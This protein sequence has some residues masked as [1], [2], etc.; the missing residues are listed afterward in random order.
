MRTFDY[1]GIACPVDLTPPEVGDN[2]PDFTL[3]DVDFND[4]TLAR[5]HGQRKV[6]L[7]VPSVDEAA[8]ADAVLGVSALVDDPDVALLVISRDTPVTLRRFLA[9]R[10]LMNVTALS[11]FRS[12]NFGASYGAMITDGRYAALFATCVFVID[13]NDTLVHEQF[14]E[15]LSQAPDY[16]A[17]AASLGLERAEAS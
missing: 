13:E 11:A 9:D 5:C 1:D 7:T 17:L 4:Y 6:L 12:E 10:E 16:A 15:K 8:P 2:A 14:V 3:L